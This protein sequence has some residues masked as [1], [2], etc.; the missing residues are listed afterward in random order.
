VLSP[1][2]EVAGRGDAD[3]VPFVAAPRRRA[4]GLALAIGGVVLLLA[5]PLVLNVFWLF[6]LTDVLIFAL[7]ALSLNLIM[8]IGGMPSFGHAAYYALG[9]YAVGLLTVRAGVAMPLAFV[10]GPLVA[11]LGAAVFG[12]FCVRLTQSYFIMLTLAFAQLVFAVVFKAYHL[13]GGEN[14]L[15][16]IRPIPELSSPLNYY[17]FTL[18]VVALCT[19]LLYRIAHSPF[20]YCLRAMRD[21]AR[22]AEFVGLPVWCYRWYAFIIAGLFAGVA[23]TLFAFYNGSVSPQAAFWTTS[24]RPFMAVIIGGAGTFWGPV[25]GAM[26]L[27]VLET[28]LGRFTE[29]WQLV[30]GL[31]TLCIA[32]F[33]QRGLGGLVG[34]DSRLRGWY[35]SWQHRSSR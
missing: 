19:F 7:F 35:T 23:G 25:A 1:R 18:V 4:I 20:G 9:A 34:R 31:I 10:A 6:L 32:L 11:A 8:G 24:A 33:F 22:R 2:S 21:N 14:G 26:V 5:L 16:G 13:T 17:Y 27:Q 15:P 12:F 29:H 30:L 28:Q 3:A